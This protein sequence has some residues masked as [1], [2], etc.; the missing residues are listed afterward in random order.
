VSSYRMRR[1]NMARL[2]IG[3]CGAGA[4]LADYRFNEASEEF[5]K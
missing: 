1:R 2:E 3:S 4:L 5:A